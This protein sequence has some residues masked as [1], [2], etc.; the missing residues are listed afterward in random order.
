MPN[1]YDTDFVAW[2]DEQAMLLRKRRFELL[3]L[4]NLI[5]EVEDLAGNN[6]RALGSALRIV[7]LHLLKWKYQPERR[8]DSWMESIDEHRSR[9]DEYLEQSPS[10]GSYL[11]ALFEQAYPRARRQ[12]ARQTR[13]PLEAFPEACPWSLEQ[14]LDEGFWPEATP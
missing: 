12:A 5:E 8:T 6:R 10:L 13:S 11:P 2:A 7:L 3:D 1:L 4:D 9:I 14:V